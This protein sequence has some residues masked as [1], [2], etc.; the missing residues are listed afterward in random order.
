MSPLT[1]LI[2][3]AALLAVL[4]ATLASIVLPYG[5]PEGDEV[6]VRSETGI[7]IEFDSVPCRF[8]FLQRR[9]GKTGHINYT[10]LYG[11]A[12]ETEKTDAGK[13]YGNIS[14]E[15]STVRRGTEYGAEGVSTERNTVRRRSVRN[16][17]RY[18]GGQYKMQC[19]TEVDIRNGVRYGSR[20]HGKGYGT[21][22]WG[23]RST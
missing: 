8:P 22:A 19:G 4:P 16:E 18:G 21:E 14:T 12:Y 9:M 2:F 10:Y 1:R 17:V 20:L 13:Q 3:L 23:G 5:P 15:Q 7:R 11:M 6:S